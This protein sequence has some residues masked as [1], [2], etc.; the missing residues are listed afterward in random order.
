MTVDKNAKQEKVTLAEIKMETGEE[1]A[2]AETEN[3]QADVETPEKE[4]F[5]IETKETPMDTSCNTNSQD[6]VD[7]QDT[8]DSQ[9]TVKSETEN[10][11]CSETTSVVNSQEEDE[12]KRESAELPSENVCE[13][14]ME[15]EEKRTQESV[16]QVNGD[17]GLNGTVEVDTR[18][19]LFLQTPLNLSMGSKIFHS[20]SQMPEAGGEATGENQEAAKEETTKTTVK[21]KVEPS[22]RSE[23]STSD[24][25]SPSKKTTPK[26]GFLSI[27][28]ML[29][30]T[31][32][33]SVSTSG[34]FP[35]P[36]ITSSS[37][38]PPSVPEDSK[39]NGA[40]GSWFSILPRMPCD[41]TSLLSSP[42]KK[43]DEESPNNSFADQFKQ[44][45]AIP[46]F[47]LTPYGIY[48]VPFPLMHVGQMNSFMG[49]YTFPGVAPIPLQT[50][51]MNQMDQTSVNPLL[52]LA[53]AIKVKTEQEEEDE[54]E[55]A[56]LKAI[57]NMQAL[58]D[59]MENAKMEPI[60][61]G[62][63]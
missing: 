12:V 1:C 39:L 43:E 34:H 33:P 54:E 6:T 59:Q 15:A 49:G 52:P 58:L 23:V 44:A 51:H 20:D 50:L 60:P 14:K 2:K 42:I 4:K 10:S 29:Q 55:E 3:Q 48:H 61:E 8:A 25:E 27:D 62:L 30:K 26:L 22:E 9:D 18:E 13:E 45:A 47:G 21:P 11:S 7:S 36:P 5:D 63:S 19:N 57:A 56:D 17:I 35:L 28:S 38:T 40:L 16:P 53:N 31:D 37:T 24:R 41:D 32:K 46:A